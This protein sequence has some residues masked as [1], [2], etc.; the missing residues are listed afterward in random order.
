MVLGVTYIVLRAPGGLSWI[1]GKDKGGVIM[2]YLLGSM[3]YTVCGN[4]MMRYVM[5]F[6]FQINAFCQM[7]VVIV[8]AIYAGRMLSNHVFRGGK[9]VKDGVYND[10]PLKFTKGWYVYSLF[11]P[12]LM[13]AFA[14]PLAVTVF[15]E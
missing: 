3:F 5:G 1:I 8:T 15:I 2:T 7:G 9:P 12:S 14:G 4:T 13:A 11:G 6:I 10:Y